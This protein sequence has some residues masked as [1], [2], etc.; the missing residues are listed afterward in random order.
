MET[1]FS[2]E[3]G[4]K[5]TAKA[6]FLSEGNH[7]LENSSIKEDNP[8]DEN[9]TSP[10][11]LGNDNFNSTS[12]QTERRVHY[13]D[14]KDA[15]SVESQSATTVQ[16]VKMRIYC[17]RRWLRMS[18]G[19]Q[20]LQSVR[21]SLPP[22]PVSSHQSTQLLNN[23]EFKT[24]SKSTGSLGVTHF[25]ETLTPSIAP[26]RKKRVAWNLPDESDLESSRADS[27]LEAPKHAEIDAVIQ[28]IDNAFPQNLT[29]SGE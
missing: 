29:Y 20:T 11:S 4:E 10:E 27:C 9:N 2:L 21:N 26:S 24:R 25:S 7:G 18:P 28:W 13:A 15:G 23:L 3:D 19:C 12:K 6:V 5:R 1:T 8:E 22:E 17:D 16:S 14:M